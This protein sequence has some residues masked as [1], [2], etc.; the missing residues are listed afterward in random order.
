MFGRFIAA[1][2]LTDLQGGLIEEAFYAG[3]MN[4]FV[5]YDLKYPTLPK[6][7]ANGAGDLLREE[8]I[9]YL[10]RKRCEKN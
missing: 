2:G 8:L 5:L 10:M 9:N 4:A 3:F 6:H 1:K 7:K